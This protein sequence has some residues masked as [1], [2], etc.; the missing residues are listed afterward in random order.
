MI[1]D[2]GRP[3]DD[4][5]PSTPVEVIGLPELPEP[6]DKFY[7]VSDEKK[8]K[9][10]AGTRA[11]KARELSLAERQT[12][13]LENLTARLA[14]QDVKEVRIILKADVMGSLE[15]IRQ[16]LLELSTGE[17]KVNILHSG[18]GGITETDVDL[19]DASKA[20]IMGFNSVPEETARA[21][22]E[23]K[24]IQIR[25]YNVI[26]DI[27]DDVK[28]AME[29]ML[30]PEEKE[31][32]LGHAEVRQVFKASKIGNIAGCYVTDGLINRTGKV[33]LV[34]DGVVI[35]T[36]RLA[37]LRRIKEDVREVKAGFECGAR[38]E[39]YD[40]IKTGDRLECFEVALEKRTL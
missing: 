18:L 28:K 9:E 17:V 35:Y 36:G 13:T 32:V 15:P 40:D 31:Q 23:K 38:I 3:V 33:R 22:A 21:A 24:G 34:R 4:A 10:V 2:H 37:S 20:V 30:S 27:V 29:G 19:A 5:G 8:A 16:S 1:D 7:V 25:F 11:R 12:V 6:G 26:Y 14:A 39:N